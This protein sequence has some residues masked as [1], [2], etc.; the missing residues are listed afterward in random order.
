MLRNLAIF[1]VVKYV[2]MVTFFVHVHHFKGAMLRNLAIFTDGKYV[3]L[4]TF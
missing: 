2:H 4:V 3:H 1:K